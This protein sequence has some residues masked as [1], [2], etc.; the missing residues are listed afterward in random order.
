[1]KNKFYIFDWQYWLCIFLL[2]FLL[3]MVPFL[4]NNNEF[5]SLAIY[6]FG[7]AL[8][9]AISFFENNLKNKIT[10]I[11]INDEIIA[12]NIVKNFKRNTI[13][14]NRKDL[15]ACKMFIYTTYGIK[16]CLHF[17]IKSMNTNKP[18]FIDIYYERATFSIIK[19][20]FILKKYITNFTYDVSPENTRLTK[21]VKYFLENSFK[22]SEKDKINYT[23][24]ILV[25]LFGCVFVFYLMFVLCYFE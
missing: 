17:E 25:L 18:E 19:Q 11:T 23:T 16:I 15:V 2:F 6:R 8:I 21:S 12:F 7:V 22:H 3:L 4:T 20:L 14:L 5:F 1:M 13:N 24:V 9:F 10:G